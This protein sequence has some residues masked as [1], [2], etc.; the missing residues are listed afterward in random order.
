MGM[1][2]HCL[3]AVAAVALC[4]VAIPAMAAPIGGTSG[5][6]SDMASANIQKV[7]FRRCWWHHGRR[8][9]RWYR[10]SYGYYPY[11]YDYYPSYGYGPTF[12]FAFGGHGHHGH[13][14]HHH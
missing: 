1:K 4:A 5:L 6:K 3:G 2:Q 13:G 14:G 8:V 7:D 12:G 10:R 11:S 9:C